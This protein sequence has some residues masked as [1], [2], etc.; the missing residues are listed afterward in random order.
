MPLQLPQRN[1]LDNKVAAKQVVVDSVIQRVVAQGG[2]L[3]HNLRPHHLREMLATLH[4][5]GGCA[6]AVSRERQ[7]GIAL[8]NAS[9]C[10][11]L[12]VNGLSPDMYPK[13]V[14]LMDLHFPGQFGELNHSHHFVCKFRK[15]LCNRVRQKQ[16]DALHGLIP[17]LRVPSDQVRCFD[18]VTPLSG[19]TVLV[20]LKII[21]ATNGEILPL[22]V[23]LPFLTT[24]VAHVQPPQSQWL[25]EEQAQVSQKADS[26]KAMLGY[27]KPEK[28]ADHL[29]HID[30]SFQITTAEAQYLK[31]HDVADGALIGPDSCGVDDALNHKE[32]IRALARPA[33][34]CEWHA[35]VN[36]AK[37]TDRLEESLD[38]ER[39]GLLTRY[40]WLARRLR[41]MLAYGQGQKVCRAVAAHCQTKWKRP[42][43]VQKDGTRTPLYESLRVPTNLLGN[44]NVSVLSLLVL[45]KNN[46]R[47]KD[48]KSLSKVRRAG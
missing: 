12:L 9:F 38:G 8:R 21:T 25:G 34:S 4:S 10:S 40:Y 43:A 46:E 41:Q 5:E 23:G 33:E 30:R 14:N 27:H 2:D 31:S 7:L 32:G 20:V 24:D 37:H 44:L 15:A 17:A 18:S 3:V 26:P 19:D 42:V 16:V 1:A 6:L 45:Q 47:A 28:I 22:L 11:F 39:S 35:A 13:L 36:V 48:S 29:L